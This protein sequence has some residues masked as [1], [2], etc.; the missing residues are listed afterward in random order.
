M[1]TEANRHEVSMTKDAQYH[2]DEAHRSF[3]ILA[4]LLGYAVTRQEET[5][6]DDAS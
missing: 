2:L 3:G 4:T 6:G 5:V 1:I